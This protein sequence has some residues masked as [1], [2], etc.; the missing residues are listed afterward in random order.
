MAFAEF[1]SDFRPHLLV[2]AVKALARDQL[3]VLPAREN[4][5]FLPAAIGYS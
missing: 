4:D 1:R 5:R 3:L 2:G